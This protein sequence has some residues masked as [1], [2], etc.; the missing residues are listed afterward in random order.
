MTWNAYKVHDTR[1]TQR[2]HSLRWSWTD[3]SIEEARG[4]VLSRLSDETKASYLSLL[5]RR[6]ITTRVRIQWS[7]RRRICFISSNYNFPVYQMLQK[8]L[9]QLELILLYYVILQITSY[10]FWLRILSCR[11]SNII[12][13]EG[14]NLT[15]Y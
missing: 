7:F 4:A 1:I 8:P 5:F 6:L 14:F 13:L 10:R 9:P 12:R 3:C 2:M 15:K 11:F